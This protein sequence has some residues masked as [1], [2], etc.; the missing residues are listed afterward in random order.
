MP[1]YLEE[2]ALA[3]TTNGPKRGVDQNYLHLLPLIKM[4]HD[5]IKIS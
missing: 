3:P 4:G 1:L 2:G 5:L